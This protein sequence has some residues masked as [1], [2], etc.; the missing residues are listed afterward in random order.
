MDFKFTSEQE[1]VVD[2]ATSITSDLA[3]AADRLAGGLF[4]DPDPSVLGALARAGLLGLAIPEK[5]GGSGLGFVESSLVLEQVGASL[6]RAPLIGTLTAGLAI[7]EFGTD[8]HHEQYLTGLAEGDL[9]MSAPLGGSS[10]RARRDGGTWSIRGAFDLVPAALRADRVLLSAAADDGPQLFLVRP[11]AEGLEWAES[12]LTDGSRVHGAAVDVTVPDEDR[13]RCGGAADRW[14]A[15]RLSVGVTAMALGVARAAVKLAAGYVSQREQFGRPIGT[16]QA[17]SY[18][19]ADSYIDLQAMEV[20]SRRAAWC[21]SNRSHAPKE[22]AI[23]KWWST[24]AG[25]RVIS[26]ALHVHGG[27]GV[28]LDYPMHRYLVAFKVLELACGSDVAHLAAL[29]RLLADDGA[30]AEGVHA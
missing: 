12:I 15:E 13:L 14:L 8:A 25:Q 7:T 22:V 2:L 11:D 19:L 5:Y 20:T 3:A 18:Q 17:V 10:L 4:G 1:A 21:L 16:F 6:L 30:V 23:A 28:D 26:T 29:A 27:I 24:T 9:V